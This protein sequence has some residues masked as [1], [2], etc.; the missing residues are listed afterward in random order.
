MRKKYNL[1]IESIYKGSG[2]NDTKIAW[3]ECY[4]NFEYISNHRTKEAFY[5]GIDTIKKIIKFGPIHKD[6]ILHY[7]ILN[8]RL[9]YLDTFFYITIKKR[10]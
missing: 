4:C 2:L 9:F 5:R 8:Y 1:E 6:E 3:I 7:E 10:I